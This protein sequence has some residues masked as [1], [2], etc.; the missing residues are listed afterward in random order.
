MRG[1]DKSSKFYEIR[2]QKRREGERGKE[3]LK[4]KND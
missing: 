2:T 1:T 4:E 3:Y